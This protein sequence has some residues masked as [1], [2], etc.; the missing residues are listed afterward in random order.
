MTQFLRVVSPTGTVCRCYLRP[1]TICTHQ[2]YEPHV[3]DAMAR[4]RYEQLSPI[5]QVLERRRV[6]KMKDKANEL[7]E[8]EIDA[9]EVNKEGRDWLHREKVREKL[10]A[11][12][13]AAGQDEKWIHVARN[14]D[15]GFVEE[16][17]DEESDKS[18]DEGS[19]VE[20]A[21]G[22]NEEDTEDRGD[23]E[24]DE[25]DEEDDDDDDDE[26][27]D[28]GEEDSEGE[29]SDDGSISDDEEVPSIPK[30]ERRSTVSIARW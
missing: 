15:D 27:S 28:Y 26:D 1:G 3:D 9:K 18:E 2:I 25:E 11:Q 7:R 22:D 10:V 5:N 23:V 24:S 12:R 29:D 8:L 21:D 6:K 4:A 14:Y 16:D 17:D 20:S 13:S 19:I 30:H